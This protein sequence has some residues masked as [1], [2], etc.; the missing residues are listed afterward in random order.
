M[1][2]ERGPTKQTAF[3]II[4]AHFGDVRSVLLHMASLVSGRSVAK[5]AA[6]DCQS[7]AISQTAAA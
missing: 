5:A 2:L 3:C 1:N 7:A 4:G 6:A